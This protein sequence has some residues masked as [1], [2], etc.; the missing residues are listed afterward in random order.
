[1][2]CYSEHCYYYGNH[3]WIMDDNVNGLFNVK[4]IYQHLRILCYS[5]VETCFSLNISFYF[6]NF[7]RRR[8]KFRCWNYDDK[9]FHVLTIREVTVIFS[10]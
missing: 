5:V 9:S 10:K 1:M 6:I 4:F 2:I 3:P 8:V 7:F